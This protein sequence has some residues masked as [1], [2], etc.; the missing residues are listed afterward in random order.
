[1]SLQK[2]HGENEERIRWELISVVA[3]F[4]QRVFPDFSVNSQ[5]TFWGGLDRFHDVSKL[6]DSHTG[7][8]HALRGNG[9][10]T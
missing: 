9:G 1:M 3:V 10:N 6:T 5:S 2:N 8:S 7:N 4:V